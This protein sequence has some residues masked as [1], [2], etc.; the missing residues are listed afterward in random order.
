LVNVFLAIF[1]GCG[2]S[3]E[4]GFEFGN[5]ECSGDTTIELENLARSVG[6]LMVEMMNEFS[7]FRRGVQ[8]PEVV[9]C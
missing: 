2:R 4:G 5:L 1:I 6:H 8:T 9:I 7:D 3:L